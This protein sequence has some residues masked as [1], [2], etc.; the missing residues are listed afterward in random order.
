MKQLVFDF[1]IED[2]IKELEKCFSE[3]MK[4]YLFNNELYRRKQEINAVTWQSI[5]SSS[6][7]I[8]S[9]SQHK[10]NFIK[11]QRQHHW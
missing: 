5:C 3:K 10:L 6:Q 9:H 8:L 4:N 2:H 1:A 11:N 7:N